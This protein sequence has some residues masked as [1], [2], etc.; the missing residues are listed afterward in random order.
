[1]KLSILNITVCWKTRIIPVNKFTKRTNIIELGKIVYGPRDRYR[2]IMSQKLKIN[3][4]VNV[5]LLHKN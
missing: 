1:M 5:Y 4:D 3:V 2:F